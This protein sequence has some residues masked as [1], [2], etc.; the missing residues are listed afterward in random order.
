MTSNLSC[1]D[2]REDVHTLLTTIHLD[3]LTE[4]ESKFCKAILTR[5]DN[6]T[7]VTFIEMKHLKEIARRFL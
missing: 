5:M 6:E 4:A 1:A 3:E 7:S 2:C